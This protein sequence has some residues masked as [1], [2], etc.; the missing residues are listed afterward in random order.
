MKTCL[1]CLLG[2]LF[3]TPACSNKENNQA[4]VLTTTPTSTAPAQGGMVIDVKSNTLPAPEAP[5]NPPPAAEAEAPVTVVNAPPVEVAQAPAATTTT[6]VVAAPSVPTAAKI[7]TPS[8]TE[9]VGVL[10]C[11]NFIDKYTSCLGKNV[12]EPAR[13][14]LADNL[15][16]A[17]RNWQDMAKTPQGATDLKNSCITMKDRTRQAMSVYGCAW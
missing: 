9:K 15:D 11:D 4:A 1:C 13:D 7:N 5:N 6:T 2:I 8:T 14:A 10:E 17:I 16:Q 12:P 3:L